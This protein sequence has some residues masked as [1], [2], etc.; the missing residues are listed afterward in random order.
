MHKTAT[1]TV[2]AGTDLLVKAVKK[3]SEMGG[4]E[5]PQGRF[6]RVG[7]CILDDGERDAILR[8]NERIDIC[9]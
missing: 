7:F 2:V 8:E 5:V 9:S 3:G 1:G 6:C 4:K